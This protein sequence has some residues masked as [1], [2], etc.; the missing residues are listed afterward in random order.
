[1][2]L[3]ARFKLKESLI[4]VTLLIWTVG[5]QCPQVNAIRTATL[6]YHA[7]ILVQ[8][9]AKIASPKESTLNVQRNAL[10]S[11]FAVTYAKSLV[12]KIAHLA[13]NRNAR[14]NV[15]THHVL[16]T[17]CFLAICA[18]KNAIISVNIPHALKNVLSLA[19]ENHAHFLAQNC[20]TASIL[21]LDSAV[22]NASKYVEHVILKMKSLT[23]FLGTKRRQ[24]QNS[25]NWIADTPLRSMLWTIT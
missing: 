15:F 6:Y 11:R 9:S 3:I 19:I 13:Q 22:R 23:Y 14:P 25:L 18:W 4:A 21:A 2:E 7:D 12:L 1:M 20:L 17:V 24:I 8:G 5:S 16:R 10:E